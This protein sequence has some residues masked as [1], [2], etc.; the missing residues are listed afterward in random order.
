MAKAF[1]S[2]ERYHRARF[3][4]SVVNSR[5]ASVYARDP[6]II[7]SAYGRRI[8]GGEISEDPAVVIYVARKIRA[9]FV[10]PSHLL[11]RRVYV[12][13]EWIEVDVVETG[14]IYPHTFASKVRPATSGISIGRFADSPI[15]AGT[16]GALVI[17]LSPAGK[18]STQILSCNHVLANENAGT[19]GD[20]IVQPGTI[21]GGSSPADN[22]ATL[23]R[24]VTIN[25]TG[26]VV[27]CAIATVDD[28][29]TVVNAMQ[30][31]LMNPPTADHPAVGLL[32][33]GGCN[34]TFMN[35]IDQVLSQ[36]NVQFLSGANTTIAPT[37]GMNVEKVGRTTEYTTSSILEIDAS[38]TV[39]YDFGSGAFVHQIATAWM[40]SPGDSGAVVCRGGKGGNVD[41]CST[42]GCASTSAAQS[43]L[44]VDLKLDV[45]VEKEFRER[46]LQHTSVGRFL[47]NLY[48]RNES[49]I[50]RRLAQANV[51]AEDRRYLRGQYEKHIGAIR[52]GLMQPGGKK[53]YFNE[54]QLRAIRELI[55]RASKYLR[56]DEAG[57][58]TELYESV[59][60]RLGGKTIGAMLKA[61]DDKRLLD[62][63][64]RILSAIEGL[65]IGDDE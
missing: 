8:V 61:L 7:G 56:P 52:Q 11:P 1:E 59:A 31:N 50:L 9:E 62:R 19:A 5:Y 47:I 28:P 48:F 17:D 3:L 39:P 4:A 36:L 20:V 22:I 64:H 14:P 30:N 27:D 34:R 55:E 46:Y 13:S 32:F 51:S 2:D 16:L 44:G 42:G 58:A 49:T 54:D 38:L 18:R 57:A 53:T 65:A 33:A 6:N 43:L 15:D 41:N 40:S 63:I 29:A 21:D 23:T 37:V 12:G 35:P 60:K 45:A 10:P 26:N 24:F 25:A